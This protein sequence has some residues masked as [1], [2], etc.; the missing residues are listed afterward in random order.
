VYRLVPA[1]LDNR[2]PPGLRA[3]GRGARHALRDRRQAAGRR[4]LRRRGAGPI[5]GDSRGRGRLALAGDRLGGDEFC[6]LL[7]G[8]AAEAAPSLVARVVGQLAERNAEADRP[9]KLSLSLGVTES[10]LDE[11]VELWDLVA[12]ADAQMFEARR[13]KKAARGDSGR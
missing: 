13:A 10:P 6:A 2:W 3:G 1:I 7:V 4:R 9:W 11:E 5:R 8:G 12:A